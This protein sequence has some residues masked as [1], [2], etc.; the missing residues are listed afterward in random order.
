MPTVKYLGHI[1]NGGFGCVDLVETEDGTKLARKTFAKNQP[2]SDDLLENV[3]KSFG[4]E[5]RVQ[6]SIVHQNI[7]P[8]VDFDLAA[9]PP[10]YLMPVAESNLSRDVAENKTLNG[11]FVAA[12]SD[13]VAGLEEMHSMQI[14]HRDLKPQNVL[15]FTSGIG[16][17][18]QCYYAVSDF[19]LISMKESQLSALTST[20]MARQSDYYTAPE[21]TKDLRFA[22]VQSDIYSLGCI[23]HDMIGLEDRIPCGEIREVGEFG[24]ILLGCTRKDP[25]QRFKSAKAVLDA[26]LSVD[27]GSYPAPTQK[28]I[29]FIAMLDAA[30]PPDNAS[31]KSLAE[32]LDYEAQDNDKRAICLK[33][34]ADRI[35]HVCDTAPE[36][37]NRIAMIFAGWVKGSSFDFEYCD[38]LANRLE[39][40]FNA[41]DFE[42]KVECLIAMLEMGTSHN[43]WYVERKFASLCG[44]AME[45]NLAKRLAVQFRISDEDVCRAIRHLE[46]SISFS[47]ESLHPLL[48]KALSEICT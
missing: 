4:K 41:V 20:G 11:Q 48:A 16:A 37:A 22:S 12:L 32:F 46:V 19:G 40:F 13:V 34:G 18:A 8:I 43:R 44:P 17:D 31:W 29:D 9:D 24:A 27:S 25:K 10:Y 1:E 42:P 30:T 14:F 21:I 28:S 47:R 5:I 7:V 39:A 23:L 38:A 33:L 15:R 6:K 36:E 26:V 2:L 3:L 35:A 45:L